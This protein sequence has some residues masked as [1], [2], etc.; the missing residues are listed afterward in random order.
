MNKSLSN[1]ELFEEYGS[2]VRLI[3]CQMVRKLPANIEY[4]DLVQVGYLGLKRAFDLFEKSEGAQFTTYAAIKIRG[5]ILDDLRTADHLGGTTRRWKQKML[6]VVTSLE[7]E[8]LR[9]PTEGEVATA[10][11]MDLPAYRLFVLAANAGPMRLARSDSEDSSDGMDQFP[12]DAEVDPLS[13]LIHKEKIEHLVRA[14][15]LLPERLSKVLEATYDEDLTLEKIAERL[16]L[17]SVRV[18][19]ILKEALSALRVKVRK[20][21]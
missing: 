8:L 12:A 7:H 21:S 20:L 13:I 6:S 19:Q 1:E 17:S 5:A 3:A 9:K 11:Q 18:S 4:D 14:F 2:L 15:E 10:L 16:Q